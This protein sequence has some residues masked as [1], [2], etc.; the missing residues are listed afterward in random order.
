MKLLR[1][2]LWA[3]TSAFVANAH[4]LPSPQHTCVIPASKD[5]RDDAPAIREAF[6]K[7]GNNGKVVFQK[8]TTYSI[9]TA[10]QLHNLKNVQVDLFGTLEYSTDVRYWIL[11]GSYYYF[12]NISIAMEFSGEYIT[13]D[14]HGSG[15]IDG[16]GQVWNFVMLESQNILVDNITL[17]ST[18]DDFQANPGNLGNTDGF[19]TINS[20][21]I[22]IQNS[23]A[24]VGDDCVSFKPGS[25]N[26][27]VKNLTCYNS[28]GIA[29]G[30]LGH[31]TEVAMALTSKL[32]L[33]SEHI[34][35][36]KV[37][38]AAMAMSA[39]SFSRTFT[40]KTLPLRPF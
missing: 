2:V 30:S 5:G 6:S 19:D 20:N 16:Q 27:H 8:D 9:Q 15:T 10:L 34:G 3:F 17:S 14:G 29:I 12:Q 26:I 28:A 40:S 32:T 24:N 11:H 35:L 39:M 18:S 22:T 33:A 36:R 7:C 37:A 13:I 1:P 31:Y 38:A 23:W 4:S 21:N 25:T